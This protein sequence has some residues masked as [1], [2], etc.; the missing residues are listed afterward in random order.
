MIKEPLGSISITTGAERVGGEITYNTIYWER[1]LLDKNP[2]WVQSKT[3][4]EVT[5]KLNMGS[6]RFD[7]KMYSPNEIIADIQFS[8]VCPTD[9]HERKAFIDRDALIA[10]FANKQ[11]MLVC[12]DIEVCNDYYRHYSEALQG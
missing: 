1:D 12:D 6:I 7:K 8:V 5:F 9:G 2:T 4:D 10:I 11:V 3:A